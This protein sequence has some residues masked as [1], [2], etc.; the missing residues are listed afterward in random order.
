[1][2]KK[3]LVIIDEILHYLMWSFLLERNCPLL[4]LFKFCVTREYWARG[5][6]GNLF[7]SAEEVR[8][9]CPPSS[10]QSNP[11]FSGLF[12]SLSALHSCPLPSSLHTMLWC[13]TP[14]SSLWLLCRMSIAASPPACSTW[15]SSGSGVT[16]GLS[17]IPRWCWQ[18][19]IGRQRSS[20]PG[21]GWTGLFPFSPYKCR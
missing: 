2:I 3:L 9:W 19:R 10:A 5:V 1:M 8:W 13:I 6:C 16:P 7:W 17:S 11:W 15:V 14:G 20:C 21:I 12:W 18:S 4:C